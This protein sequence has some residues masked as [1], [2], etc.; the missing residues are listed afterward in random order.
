MRKAIINCGNCKFLDTRGIDPLP[1]KLYPCHVPAENIGLPPSIK[2]SVLSPYMRELMTPEDGGNCPCFV[3]RTEQ[4][5]VPRR[6]E[7]RQQ[8]AEMSGK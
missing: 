6:R 8:I 5:A 1:G 3:E 7:F 2:P 4:L